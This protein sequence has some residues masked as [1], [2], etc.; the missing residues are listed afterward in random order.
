MF[1]DSNSNE[2]LKKE[3]ILKIK[4]PHWLMTVRIYDNAYNLIQSVNDFTEINLQTGFYEKEIVLKPGIYEIEVTLANNTSR[5]L[6]KIKSDSKTEFETEK[7]IIRPPGQDSDN[8]ERDTGSGVTNTAISWSSYKS[9]S[10]G[11]ANLCIHIQVPEGKLTEDPQT[12]DTIFNVKRIANVRLPYSSFAASPVIDFSLDIKASVENG[13]IFFNKDLPAGY[14]I[15]E[16]VTSEKDKSYQPLYLHQGWSTRVFISTHIPVCNSFYMSICAMGDEF[17][18]DNEEEIVAKA[19]LGTLNQEISH[20]LIHK[21][22]MKFLI[23]HECRNPWLGILAAYALIPD[24]SKKNRNTEGNLENETLLL[25]ILA[26]LIQRLPDHPDVQALCLTREAPAINPFYFPPLLYKGLQRV[27]KHAELFESTILPDSLTDVILHSVLMDTA[28]VNWRTLSVNSMAEPIAGD[29]VANTGKE[30]KITL[31]SLNIDLK[32][33]ISPKAPVFNLTKESTSSNTVS[34]PVDTSP[35]SCSFS[36]LKEVSLINTMQGI[37]K[38]NYYHGMPDTFITHSI[39]S[40]FDLIK[41]GNADRIVHATNL[42]V[43]RVNAG[44]ASIMEKRKQLSNESSE[45]LNKIIFNTEEQLIMRY[46]LQET[47]KNSDFDLTNIP[48]IS[49]DVIVD[50]SEYSVNPDDTIE[51]CFSRIRTEAN[52]ILKGSAE[53]SAE[54]SN[55]IGKAF[56]K[57]AT[58]ILKRADFIVTT[59]SDGQIIYGNGA[60]IH[61]SGTAIGNEAGS[62]KTQNRKENLSVWEHALKNLPLGKSIFQISVN[63]NIFNTWEVKRSALKE[64]D[65]QSLDCFINVLRGENAKSLNSEQLQKIADV[66]STLELFA[67]LSALYSEQNDNEYIAELQ[68]IIEEMERLLE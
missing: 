68:I 61:L 47:D 21:E 62:S 49:K 50:A 66:V 58:E 2:G 34:D 36:T 52:R 63:N 45:Q 28:W 54:Q 6:I 13:E 60:F 16:W 23:T 51:E 67:P 55:N 59:N 18:R 29:D 33:V 38:N 1:L 40:I 42:P 19:I 48:G 64:K 53:K 8:V 14:Y 46:A 30:I 9:I 37:T 35:L 65:Q 39:D 41:T 11:D 7:S 10:V 25:E 57:I 3:G 24:L 4:V 27:Y 32:G 17:C 26:F 15:I 12:Y 44:I 31:P 5:T 20:S 56:L 43:S 22:Q